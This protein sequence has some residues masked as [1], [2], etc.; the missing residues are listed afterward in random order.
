[1]SSRPQ[2]QAPAQAPVDTGDRLSFTIFLALAFHAMLIFGVS[3]K[4]PDAGAAAPTLDV[5]LASHRTEQAPEQADFLA[6]HNQQASGTEEQARKL[7]AER[8]AEFADTQVRD[9]NPAPQVQAAAPSERQDQQVTT[10]VGESKQKI[11]LQE[12]HEPREERLKREGA[13]QEQPVLSQ[14][15]ASLQAQLARQQQEYAKR[16]RIHRLT[17][18]ATRASADAQYL[19]EW[20]NRVERTGNRNY[21]QEAL[22]RRI[23]GSLRLS[24]SVKPDGTI[25]SVEILQS[26]G[27]SILDQA[28]VQ[29]VHLAAPFA[30][31]PAEIRQ[32]Y[33]RLEIIRTWNFDIA[34]LSTSQ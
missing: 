5:T 6:Q 4:L 15:I 9:I 2:P 17:S 27:Q 24:V 14:E 1:M 20:S 29:I 33:D 32:E 13:L 11:Q 34:G 7:T 21:P 16:P 18:V 25:E 22:N 19:H 23:T 30:S 28:A 10:T 3:F 12:D 8:R 26:S 31:F